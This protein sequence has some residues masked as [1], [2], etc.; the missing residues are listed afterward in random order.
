MIAAFFRFAQA[1]IYTTNCTTRFL[2]FNFI[3]HARIKL[4]CKISHEIS[5]EIKLLGCM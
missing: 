4:I 3:F 2:A 1:T 5:Y